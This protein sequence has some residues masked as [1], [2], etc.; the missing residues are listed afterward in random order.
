MQRKQL[1]FDQMFDVRAVRIVVESI[2]QCYAALGV[3][4]A[5]WR[6]VPGEFDDYI[7]TPKDNEYRS[8][9]TAVIGPQGK[10]LEVQNRSARATWTS[11]PSSV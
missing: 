11:T 3:V 10:S 6:Y 9:H 8:I 2:E 1:A 4:H 5:L 7:A